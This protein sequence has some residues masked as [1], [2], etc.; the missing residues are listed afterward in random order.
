MVMLSSCKMRGQ[1]NLKPPPERNNN[2]ILSKAA[3]MPPYAGY[4]LR[5]SNHQ[6]LY[7][8]KQI[9][10]QFFQRKYLCFKDIFFWMLLII[11]WRISL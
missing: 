9:L 11:T 4:G 8:S 2:Q 7:I 10:F 3:F 1:L 6:S 5:E